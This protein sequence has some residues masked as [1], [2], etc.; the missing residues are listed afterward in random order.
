MGHISHLQ[1]FPTILKHRSSTGV[2]QQGKGVVK[3]ITTLNCDIKL[4]YDLFMY[5]FI[6]YFI[7]K[8]PK[9]D[10]PQLCIE[11]GAPRFTLQSVLGVHG[12][13][14]MEDFFFF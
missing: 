2:A 6:F 1:T 5:L 14:N 11:A 10:T 4:I 12:L 3:L 8:C 13:E 7:Y 9:P